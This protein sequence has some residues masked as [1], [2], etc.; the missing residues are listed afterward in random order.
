MLDFLLHQGRIMVAGRSGGQK[1][2]DLTER[3]LPTWTS[4]DEMSAD[5]V[6]Y[7]GAQRSLQALGV[8]NASQISFHFLSGRYPNLKATLQRLVADSKIFPVDILNGTV[9]KGECYVHEKDLQT[10]EA[11][12]L[13][14]W[15]PRTTLLSPFDNLIIDRARTKNLFNFELKLETYSP[16]HKRRY[17]YYVLPILHDDRLIGRIDPAMD[18][19]N[20]KLLVKVV[21]AE[22]D[23]PRQK[24]VSTKIATSTQQLAEFLGAKE[25][26]TR[27]MFPNFGSLPSDDEQQSS[28]TI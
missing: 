11:L 15:E 22:K 8:A 2:W 3:C 23:A 9:G 10:L 21:H 16:K 14:D 26:A 7:E 18:R 13:G 1:L 27:S 19:E 12:N 17:G 6:E 25:V 28:R 20:E 5:D 4:K 24:E